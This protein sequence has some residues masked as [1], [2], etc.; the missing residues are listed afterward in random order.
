MG[1]PDLYTMKRTIGFLL[2]VLCL[3]KAQSDSCV[4]NAIAKCCNNGNC[5]SYENYYSSMSGCSWAQTQNSECWC[6][7]VCYASDSG[8]CCDTNGGVSAAIS[9]GPSFASSS[10]FVWLASTANP[11]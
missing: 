9:I 5:Q 11:A 7:D 8:S 4:A 10:V 3:V 1:E 6:D 2:V